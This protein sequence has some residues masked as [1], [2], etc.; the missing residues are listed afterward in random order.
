MG[1]RRGKPYG[2][3]LRDRVLADGDAPR[4]AVA[5]RFGV[6]PSYVSKVQ[7]RLRRCGE[8]TPK[9]QGNRVA[10]RAPWRRGRARPSCRA[11]PRPRG[12]RGRRAGAP[13]LQGGRLGWRYGPGRA[14]A[15]GAAAAPP[16]APSTISVAQSTS[17]AV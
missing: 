1:W 11:G 12:C 15:S 7:A 17:S 16:R 5:A 6:S 14:R 9:P 2:Q 13:A 3:D 4:R 8:R 10:R